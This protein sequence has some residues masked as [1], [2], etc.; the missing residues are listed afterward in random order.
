MAVNAD[1]SSSLRGKC[2][3]VSDSREIGSQYDSKQLPQENLVEM[4]QDALYKKCLDMGVYL[5]KVKYETY[6]TILNGKL[7][8]LNDLKD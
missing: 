7:E 8:S 2:L 5:A 4:A 1:E 6:K 3:L